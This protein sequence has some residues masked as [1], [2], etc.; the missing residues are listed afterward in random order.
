[1]ALATAGVSQ[2]SC[3][4]ISPLS[5]SDVTTSLG[6]LCGY[7]ESA[8]AKNIIKKTTRFYPNLAITRG[9]FADIIVK[10]FDTNSPS[11]I[12]PSVIGSSQTEAYYYTDVPTTL[13]TASSINRLRATGCLNTRLSTFRPY[14]SITRGEAF[15]IMGCLVNKSSNGTTVSSS[16]TVSTQGAPIVSPSVTNPVSVTTSSS[17]YIWSTSSYG[18]CSK[19]CGE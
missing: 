16:N 11:S 3:Q 12:A 7:I 1:M 17:N 18:T 2:T 8:V 13:S 6:D 19:T 9:D 5:F 4:S 14:A 15:K 10:S